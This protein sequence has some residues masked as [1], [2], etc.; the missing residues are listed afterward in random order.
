LCALLFRNLLRHTRNS[1]MFV[2]SHKHKE[3]TQLISYIF[4][5]TKVGPQQTRGGATL[6]VVLSMD[7]NSFNK[8]HYICW[9][10]P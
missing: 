7:N 6:G 8:T 9:H 1:V 10:L 2:Y 3:G 5:Y 4:A